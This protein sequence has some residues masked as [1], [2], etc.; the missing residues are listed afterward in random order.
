M[1]S[2]SEVTMPDIKIWEKLLTLLCY[3]EIISTR[4]LN[5]RASGK[6]AK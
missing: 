3:H 1:F 2:E 5:Q 6:G 4:P